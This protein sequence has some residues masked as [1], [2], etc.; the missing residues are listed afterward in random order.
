M[1]SSTAGNR[2]ITV[3]VACYS[4]DRW[5]VT[6][7]A[8]HSLLNQDHPVLPVVV[9]DHNEEL[10]A[11]LTAWCAP[12]VTVMRNTRG[13]GASGARNTGVAAAD[14]DLVAFLDDDASAAP[15]WLSELVEPLRSPSVVGVGGTIE[16]AWSGPRP[17]WFP[18]EFGWVVGATDTVPDRECRSVRNVWSGNML[19]RREVFLRAGGFQED[20]GKVGNSREPEDTELCMRMSAVSNG[21]E[22]RAVGGGIVR[23]LVP[24]ERAKLSFFLR[25]C[26]SE[27]K[28][29]AALARV[30]GDP[31]AALSV[32]MRY[33]GTVLPRA[34]AGRVRAAF[35]GELAGLGQAS[36][37]VAGVVAAGTGFALAL[38]GGRRGAAA[39]PEPA[40]GR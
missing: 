35:G 27:G 26:W 25:R 39:R 40:P 11:R 20:F 12:N 36:V 16:P 28:G 38:A 32:E 31:H 2:P 5:H 24:A 30:S 1:T 29:K 13:R 9:V 15:N 21:G 4:S 8:I 10:C 19:V 23:H 6:C 33:L 7:E 34:V 18:R 37:I 14:T 22:W 17:W 3:V